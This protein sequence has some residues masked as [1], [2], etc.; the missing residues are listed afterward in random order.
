MSRDGD[1]GMCMCVHV[2]ACVYMHVQGF[3]QDFC[4]GGGDFFF[5][6]GKP[7]MHSMLNNFIHM[8]SATCMPL[9]VIFILNLEGGTFPGSHSMK[10]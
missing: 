5:K 8:K 2:C 7:I 9:A 6:V 3:I 10:P 1:P 4:L